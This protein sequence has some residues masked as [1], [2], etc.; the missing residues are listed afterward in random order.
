MTRRRAVL[1]IVVAL[2][3]GASAIAGAAATLGVS[4]RSIDSFSAALPAS[5]STTAAGDTTAPALTA[6]EMFDSNGNGKVDQVKAT[7]NE[8]L[9]AYTAG[10]TPPWTLTNV[11]SGGTLSS[12]SVTGT[13]ATLTIAEGPNAA[14]TAVGTFTVALAQGA[15]GIRDAAGN[16]SSFAAT[17]PVDKAAPVLLTVTDSDSGTGNGRIEDDD[18]I[19]FAFSEALDV[20]TVPSTTSVDQGD[21]SGN[22]PDTLMITNLLALTP[23]GSDGYMTKNNV[24]ARFVNSAVTLTASSTTIHVELSSCTDDCNDRGTSTGQMSFTIST[25]IKGLDDLAVTGTVTTA[26]NYGAF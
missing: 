20:A 1:V 22:T 12:V 11:P 6:L 7:F 8:T 18:W 10:T 3:C 21:P 23:M 2:L 26:T 24:V 13:L 4:S 25:A 5:T 9:A 15:N 14:D 17:S 19:E 16:N